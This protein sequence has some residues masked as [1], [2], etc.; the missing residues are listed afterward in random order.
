MGFLD[1]DFGKMVL[2]I[3][4]GIILAI[5]LLGYSKSPKADLASALSGKRSTSPSGVS[6]EN[7]YDPSNLIG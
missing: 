2:F 4:L 5:V 6:G 7:P 3:I 1:T